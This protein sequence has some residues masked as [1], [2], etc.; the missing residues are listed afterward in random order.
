MD[1]AKDSAREKNTALYVVYPLQPSNKE[2]QDRIAATLRTYVDDPDT[3]YTSA[4]RA[5]GVN[6]WRVELTDSQVEELRNK[7][8]V[9][10]SLLFIPHISKLV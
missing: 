4:T 2:H 9:L 3:I 10:D 5:L 8:E 7:P 1:N 6:F